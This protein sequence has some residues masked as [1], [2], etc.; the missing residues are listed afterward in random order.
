MSDRLFRYCE[1][2]ELTR[3][4]GLEVWASP[5]L[6]LARDPPMRQNLQKPKSW[7]NLWKL[8]VHLQTFS[9]YTERKYKHHPHFCIISILR[10]VNSWDKSPFHTFILIWVFGLMR[11]SPSPGRV[12]LLYCSQKVSIYKVNNCVK[13]KSLSKVSAWVPAAQLGPDQEKCVTI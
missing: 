7:L 8:N 13:S 4:A 11:V 3:K 6:N 9:I 2:I 12:L 5:R 1:K 10:A